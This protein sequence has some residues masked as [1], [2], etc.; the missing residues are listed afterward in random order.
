M[1]VTS[2]PLSE[3]RTASKPN[4]QWV[5][6]LAASLGIV[7]GVVTWII[8]ARYTIDGIITLINALLSFLT[9]PIR[10]ASHWRLYLYLACIPIIYSLVEWFLPPAQRINTKFHFQPPPL[11]IVWFI[12]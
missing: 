8:G 5:L 12:V 1:S 7:F 3:S 9:I 11:L 2:R 10:V 6:L 4:I